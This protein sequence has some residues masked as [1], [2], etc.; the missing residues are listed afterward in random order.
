MH[1][2]TYRGGALHAEDVSLAAL[3]EEI[4]LYPGMPADAMIKL[5]ER[6]FLDYVLEPIKHSLDRAFKE[7]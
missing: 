7:T 1:H 3:A 4:K 5:G 2:F 6:T